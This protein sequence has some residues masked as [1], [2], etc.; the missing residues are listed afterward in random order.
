VG[1]VI[2][3]ILRELCKKLDFIASIC[4]FAIGV[5]VISDVLLR[6]F[7]NSPILGTH[8]TVCILSLLMA[9]LALANCEMQGSSI[10]V[11]FFLERLS[12]KLR[13]VIEIVTGIISVVFFI[14]FAWKMLEYTIMTYQGGTV[15]G[16]YEIPL[17]Y[18]T[19]II[20]TGFALLLLAIIFNFV[21]LIKAALK[22][23]K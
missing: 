3:N 6:L 2:E 1:Q 9:S 14:Y 23:R 18:L 8:E 11:V 19:A 10:K 4:V 15:S 12:N 7:L 13:R 17:Y 20:T 22:P 16:V 21:E 5:V